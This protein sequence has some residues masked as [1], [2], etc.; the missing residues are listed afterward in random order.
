MAILVGDLQIGEV[1]TMERY[2]DGYVLAV[3]LDKVEE[4]RE[5][6]SEA[7]E[8]WMEHGALAY[9]EAVGDDLDPD[10]GEMEGMEPMTFPEMMGTG[11][12]ET[13]IFSFIVYESREHRDEVNA[14]VMEDPAMAESKYGEEAMPFDP[15]RVVYGGFRS[16]V[17]H[18][19]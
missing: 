3:P 7:G 9:L 11:P 15:E 1:I 2:V 16:I 13:V 8:L 18:E 5:M 10:M 14:R 12:D 4:Y 19:K 6:A 17:E